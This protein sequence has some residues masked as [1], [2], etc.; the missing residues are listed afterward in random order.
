MAEKLQF[1]GK[2]LRQK[3]IKASDPTL[4]Y[5][6]LETEQQTVNC[7]LAKRALTFMM[8]VIEGDQ[9]AVFG[10]FNSKKQFV[11]ERYLTQSKHDPLG[12]FLPPHLRYPRKKD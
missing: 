2:V 12:E 10:H 11:I 1:K 4:V 3:I 7:L 5:V 6:E 9:I 8:E